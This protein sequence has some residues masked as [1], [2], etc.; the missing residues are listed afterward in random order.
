MIHSKH[1][2]HYCILLLGLSLVSIARAGSPI[3]DFVPEN[4]E[5]NMVMTGKIYLHEKEVR[6]ATCVV[7]SFVN[8]ECRGKASLIYYPTLDAYIASLMIYGHNSDENKAL[9]FKCYEI[10]A[11]S[12]YTLI[13]TLKFSSNAIIGNYAAPYQWGLKV[14]TALPTSTLDCAPAFVC[15]ST[16]KGLVNV[17]LREPLMQDAVFTIHSMNG[18]LI[19]KEHFEKG[20]SV[21]DIT[22]IQA[23]YYILSI[24]GKSIIKK[25]KVLV[26]N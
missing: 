11:D 7:G 26:L 13:D 19:Y 18:M 10:D 1:I 8:G 22:N 14:K 9:T 17:Y 15:N 16:G 12:V 20:T 6:K 21:V 4:Y 3:W 5:Q 23:G 25:L 2:I 24:R